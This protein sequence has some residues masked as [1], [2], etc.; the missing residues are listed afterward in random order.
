MIVGAVAV[1]GLAGVAL[2]AGQPTTADL[3]GTWELAEIQSR[4]VQR[5]GTNRLPVFT[6]K[7]QTIEGFDGCNQFS[8]RLDKAGGIAS[9][10]RGCPDETIKLPLDLS[11][12]MSHLEAGRIERERL[13]LPARGGMPP[14]VFRRVKSPQE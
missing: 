4:P 9:T 10:R 2:C 5:S 3:N 13:V 11:D 12:A 8:G 14:S 7:D 1:L 6:I